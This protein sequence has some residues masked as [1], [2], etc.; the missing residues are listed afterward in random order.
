MK[1]LQ[2]C[3]YYIDSPL[4]QNLFNEL[5][6]QGIE[7]D[8]YVFTE[9]NYNLKTELPKNA[10]LSKCFTNFDRYIFHLKH[11]KVL[12]NIKIKIDVNEYALMHAHSLFSNGY[13]AYKLYKK[14]NIPY[15]VTVRNTDVNFFFKKL[16][17]LRSTGREILLNAK[18]IIFLS[19]PYKISLIEKYIPAELKDKILN[20]SSVITNGIDKFWLENKYFE[21][22][23]PKTNLIRLVF[24]GRINKNKNIETTIEVCKNLIAKGYQV[25]LKIIGK[26]YDTT[27]YEILNSNPFIEYIQFCNKE[28]LINHYRNSDIFIM[29]SFTET[30][31]L[32]YAEAMT[33]ALPVIY[34][35]DQGFD[36]NFTDGEIGYA[37]PCKDIE[38]ISDRIM[39][40]IDNYKEI[41]RR[42]VELSN[43]FNWEKISSNL[44]DVYFH[45]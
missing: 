10:I 36:G 40:I 37:V 34:T 19:E 22:V 6:K 4:Y 21:R 9:K 45:I 12:K 17:Y 25:G 13:I 29:P 42:C 16:K 27:S 11:Y 39:A 20:K 18:N 15:I 38:Y 28:E 2:I 43:K 24:A 41:S 30:F 14:F 33:Q 32:V 44:N 3:S 7:E 1:V 5:E 26:I 31:G 23:T 8:I 35:K